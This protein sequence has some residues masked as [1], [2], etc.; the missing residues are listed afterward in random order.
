MSESIQ[1]SVPKVT[2]AA[3]EAD[4]R[5]DSPA[6]EVTAQLYEELRRLTRS[7]LRSERPDHTL[8]TSALVSEA[9]VKLSGE[10][11]VRWQSRAHFLATAAVAMQRAPT[12]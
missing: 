4:H 6:P 12:S 10:T 3:R 5:R 9:W 7:K 2:D 1:P 8:D 11:R